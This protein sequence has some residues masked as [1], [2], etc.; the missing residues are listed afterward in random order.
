M[1]Q[2]IAI[3]VEIQAWQAKSQ[4]NPASAASELANG[5]YDACANRAYYACFHGAIAALWLAG[6]RPT[7]NEWGHDFGQ[8][9]FAGQ[10]ITR[11]K[12]Y[13]S[14]LRDTLPRLFDLRRRADYEPAG[15][16][17]T[18]AERAVRRARDF[19]AAVLGGGEPR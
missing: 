9:Q 5:R 16:S 14:E 1:Q 4:Q 10:L 3:D 7:G 13:P 17:A 15:V 12:Q 2:H 8:A 19:A 6:I 11:R 18:L